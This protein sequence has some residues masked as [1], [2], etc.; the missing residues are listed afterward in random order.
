[1]G[2]W[3]HDTGYQKHLGIAELFFVFLFF[4]S[5][6]EHLSEDQSKDN[7]PIV[8]SSTEPHAPLRHTLYLQ[9]LHISG[10][11]G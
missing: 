2:A 11:D 8:Q 7:R 1:M 9:P 6:S 10:I 3:N 4:F 5:T